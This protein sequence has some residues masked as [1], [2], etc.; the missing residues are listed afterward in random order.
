[1]PAETITSLQ[2]PRIKQTAKLRDRRQREK[3]GR[4]IIDGARELLR[5][6]E[7]GLPLDEVFLCEAHCRSD[8]SLRAL[9][10]LRNTSADIVLVTPAVFEK[11][12]FGERLEGLLAVAKTP[13]KSLA[14]LQLPPNALVAVLEGIEKPGNIGAI[15]RSADGA[16][17]S[18]VVLADGVTDLYNPNAIRASL[19]TIFTL[20]VA[21]A[22]SS[23]TLA[24]LRKHQ[25]Q[26][27]AAWVDAPLS[28]TAADYR[29]P[30]AIVLGGEAHGL[31]P[32]WAAAEIVRIGL[33]MRGIA[34]SLNVSAAAAVLC[35]EALRQRTTP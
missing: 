23:E 9:D 21:T 16:G 4:L 18:A 7:S 34:D 22:T 15:L 2:N 32:V 20:P 27:F 35:Y 28:Y 24:W 14:E 1:M 26:I 25:L 19:G 12:A 17:V 13:R 6:I 5:A 31:S 30:S 10:A 11:L 33:P 8:D 3:Q 29:G